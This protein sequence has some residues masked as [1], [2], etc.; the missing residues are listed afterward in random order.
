MLLA[1]LIVAYGLSRSVGLAALGEGV[2]PVDPVGLTT[3]AVQVVGLLAALH[4][5]QPAG[6]RDLLAARREHP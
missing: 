1:I 3:Q 2:E 6:A 4:L 5:C